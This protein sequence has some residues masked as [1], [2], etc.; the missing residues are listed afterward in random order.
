MK[1]NYGYL[2][3]LFGLAGILFSSCAT[4]ASAYIASLRGHSQQDKQYKVEYIERSQYDVADV[5]FKGNAYL[6]EEAKK[7]AEV[8]QIEPDYKGIPSVGYIYCYLIGLTIDSGN[9]KSFTFILKDANGNEILRKSGNDEIPSPEVTKYGTSWNSFQI[10]IIDDENA[11][12]PITLRIVRLD[13]EYVDIK[14]SK[15][16]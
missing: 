3:L 7:S 15:V 12:F 6:K 14:I 4:S 8:K 13:N 9:P 2:F 1:K 11:Q 5:T 10:I 16:E